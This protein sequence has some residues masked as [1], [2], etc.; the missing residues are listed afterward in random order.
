MTNTSL[1]LAA[2][3]LILVDFFLISDVTTHIAYILICFVIARSVD[4]GIQYQIIVGLLSW[5]AV[6][7]FHYVILRSVILKFANKFLSP[8]K[9]KTGA[10][11]LVGETGEVVKKENTTMIRARGDLWPVAEQ[12]K[13]QDG[14]QVKILSRKKGV[15]IVETFE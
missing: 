13:L 12:E 8:D 10:A 4:A 7:T 14:Q 2:L 6:V 5:F 3:I 15:L 11:G 9:Y 1:L